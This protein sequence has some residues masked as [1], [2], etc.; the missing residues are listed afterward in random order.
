MQILRGT[1]H[2]NLKAYSSV[3]FLEKLDRAIAFLW[4]KTH[5]FQNSL[6]SWGCK[7]VDHQ[8]YKKYLY[9][10]SNSL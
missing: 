1:G 9:V 7:E 8:R 2:C 6:P 3:K 4:K 10:Q 5:K